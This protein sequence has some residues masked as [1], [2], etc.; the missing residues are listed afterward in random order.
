[1]SEV[2]NVNIKQ[3]IIGAIVLVSLGIIFIP[4]LLNGGDSSKQSLSGDN[5]P[6]MPKKLNRVLPDAVSP[7]VMPAAKIISAYPETASEKSSITDQ[8]T[9]PSIVK[10]IKT[11]P[12]KAT[13]VKN[14]DSARTTQTTVKTNN[15]PVTKTVSGLKYQ[16]VT[17]PVSSNIRM[18]YT[19]QIA[20]FSKKDNAVALQSK[21]RKKQY[22]AYIESVKTP[23][24]RVYRLR[25]GPFLKFEQIS[26]IKNRLEKQFKL[27]NT[28][29]VKY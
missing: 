1:M 15:V 6:P 18:A 5:I 19:L 9:P 3:R 7:M 20:S 29:I 17:K 2:Q 10:K 12:V 24:G 23:K 8:K 11:T 26:A 4:L 21:L 22:K 27:K 13:A 16:K 14:K 25:V 28:I